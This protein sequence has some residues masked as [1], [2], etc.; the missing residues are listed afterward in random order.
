MQ[1]SPNFR[2]EEFQLNDPIPAVCVAAFVTLARHI[3]EPV[4]AKFNCPLVITSGYRS[5]KANAA[6]HGQP[7]SEHIATPTICAC[8]FYPLP[9]SPGLVTAQDVFDWM[10][11][12]P[13][14]PYHQLIL[15]HGVNASVVHV[16]FNASK[17]GVRIVLVG[18]TH[19][20]EPYTK[21]DYVPYQVASNRDDVQAASAG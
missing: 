2:L 5:P 13:G 20:S 18:A 17:Y 21:A 10:R 6:A 15:E 19:N 7:N 4:R 9:P 14:L 8:D 11:N 12:S 3:L 16:S 1:L